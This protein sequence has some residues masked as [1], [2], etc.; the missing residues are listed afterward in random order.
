MGINQHF[1]LFGNK[2]SGGETGESKVEKRSSQWDFQELLA[3]FFLG[4]AAWS[5]D[6]GQ[7]SNL[8]PRGSCTADS[9]AVWP[10]QG[11]RTNRTPEVQSWT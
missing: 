2:C 8:W 6:K 11:Q 5:G 9:T 3:E 4:D 7:W 1:C 10:E